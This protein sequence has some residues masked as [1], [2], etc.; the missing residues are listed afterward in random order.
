MGRDSA[1]VEQ[2]RTAHELD[3]ISHSTNT[4]LGYV[5]LLVRRYDEAIEQIRKTLALYPESSID[6]YNLGVCYEHKGM[7]SE[8]VE[9]FLKSDEGEGASKDDL[10]TRRRAFL[11]SGIQGFWREEL[12]SSISDSKHGYVAPGLLAGLYALLGEKDPAFENLE[13]AYKERDNIG[14]I[15]VEPELDNLHSDPRFADLLRRMG[16]PQ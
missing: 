13:Q 1:A 14:L 6:H 12:K 11:R 8:A 10:A 7:F 15:R 4:I 3:P 16:L 5:Y 9:E 2:I